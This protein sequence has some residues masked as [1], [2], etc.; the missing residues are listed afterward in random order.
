MTKILQ[1]K[2]DKWTIEKKEVKLHSGKTSGTLH[3]FL[4]QNMHTDC[5]VHS[6]VGGRGSSLGRSGHSMKMTTYLHLVPRL[7]MTRALLLLLICVPTEALRHRHL[8]IL[9]SSKQL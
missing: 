6:V 3:F 8:F 1:W 7:K 5:G 2:I 9:P 4:L